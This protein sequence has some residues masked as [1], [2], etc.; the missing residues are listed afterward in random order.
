M[1]SC[2]INS[3]I[4]DKLK[5]AGRKIQLKVDRNAKSILIFVNI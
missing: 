2:I 4:F 5:F 3:T 1:Y